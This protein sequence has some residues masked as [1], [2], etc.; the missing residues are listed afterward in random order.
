V[1]WK[2]GKIESREQNEIDFFSLPWRPLG[3]LLFRRRTPNK[4]HV[5]MA[6]YNNIWQSDELQRASTASVFINS[7]PNPSELP[8]RQHFKA[9]S[10]MLRPFFSTVGNHNISCFGQIQPNIFILGVVGIATC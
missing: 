10:P 4:N 1:T 8:M 5:L 3:L 2:D 7:V 6:A 9:C